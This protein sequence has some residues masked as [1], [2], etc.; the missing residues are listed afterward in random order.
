MGAVPTARALALWGA[1]A[2]AALTTGCH[3]GRGSAAP[4]T[5][6]TPATTLTPPT[7]ARRP[8]PTTVWRPTAPTA[9]PDDAA[10][11]LVQTWSVGDRHGASAVAAPA[12]VAVLFAHAYPGSGLAIPRG[13]SDSFTPIVCTYGPPGGASPNDDI[14][15]LSVSHTATGWYVSS[16]QVLGS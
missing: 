13:C 2:A 1:V 7:T 10:S 9:T 5:N 3:T 16:V 8:P 14:F 6:T 12:A 15:E 4:T 11:Q